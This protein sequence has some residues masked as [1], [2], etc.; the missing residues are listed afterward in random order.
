ML[1]ENPNR[2]LLFFFIK[3]RNKN[4]IY[5]NVMVVSRDHTLLV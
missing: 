4:Q 1:K 5:C 3:H 2:F